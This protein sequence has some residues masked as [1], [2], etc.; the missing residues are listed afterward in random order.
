MPTTTTPSSTI[1]ATATNAGFQ[2][3]IKVAIISTALDVM[4]E[5]GTTSLHTQ[6]ANLAS[7]LLRF[8]SDADVAR[9]SMAASCDGVTDGTSSDTTVK[10]RVVAL[11]NS[12]ISP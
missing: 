5:V 10:A 4:N 1:D 3:G 12:M 6:R 7:S 2:A 9:W 8:I 11:W